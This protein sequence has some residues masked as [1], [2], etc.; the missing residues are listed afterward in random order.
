MNFAMQR[1]LSVLCLLLG[2]ASA[3]L[4]AQSQARDGILNAIP[5]DALGFAVVH[6]LTDASHSID[7]VAKLVQAPPADL[8]SLAKKTTGL[9]RG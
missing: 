7:D 4:K 8:L 1:V 9:E 3:Q 5:A 6:N 2:L